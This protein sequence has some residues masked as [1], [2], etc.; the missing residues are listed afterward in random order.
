MMT[1]VHTC[2]IAPLSRIMLPAS[3]CAV[4]LQGDNHA[5]QTAVSSITAQQ[6][7]GAI[8]E[9]KVGVECE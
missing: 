7:A 6:S 9:A 4:V 3:S 2:T 1:P 8:Q 5:L